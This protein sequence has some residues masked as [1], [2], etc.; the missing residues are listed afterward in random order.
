MAGSRR[1]RSALIRRRGLCAPNMRGIRGA[2]AGG[3]GAAALRSQ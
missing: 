1:R 2:R 3:R